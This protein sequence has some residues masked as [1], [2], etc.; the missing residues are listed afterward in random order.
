MSPLSVSDTLPIDE[1]YFDVVI[2]DE[3]SQITLEEGLPP[4]YRAKQSIIVGDEMQMPPSNFFGS[5]GDNKDDLW[6]D[7]GNELGNEYFSLDADSFLTQGARKFPSIMLGWH[8]RS[9]HEALIGFS[10]ASFYNN[11]LL[12]IPDVKDHQDTQTNIVVDIVDDAQENVHFI[13]QKPI[14]YHYIKNGVYESRSNNLEAKY[15]ALL[16]KEL[17]LSENK[18]SIGIVAFSME[19]E[20]ESEIQELCVSDKVFENRLEEEYKRIEDNQ[21]VGLFVKN[22][23]NVQGDERDIIIMST[24]FGYNPKGKML[25]NFGP[26][27]RRG[28][29][30]RLNVIFSRAKKSMVVVSS[31]KYSDITNE[32]NDG[33]NYFR[34]YLQYAELMSQ[35]NM[36]AANFV[37]NAIAANFESPSTSTTLQE[38]KSNLENLGYF[39]VENVGQSKFKCDLAIKNNATDKEFLLG[40]ILDEASHYE[41]SDVL[42]QYLLKPQL[43]EFNGWK[44]CQIYAKDWLEN[45]ERVL[46]MIQ[47]NVQN[48]TF[49]EKTTPPLSSV[50]SLKNFDSDDLIL[51]EK[52]EHVNMKNLETNIDSVF[53][54]LVSTENGSNKFW[55]IACH[56][57]ELIIQ[58]GR[59]GTKGQKLIKTF[60]SESKAMQE[61]SVLIK[62]KVNKGY[63]PN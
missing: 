32:Y 54:R 52:T 8:Y 56:G 60:E 42:E 9:K 4:I 18:Q 61:M 44:I 48:G 38:I 31:I 16:I 22:L 39:V 55:E 13:F 40:I 43:L 62:Q 10:N 25:M 1:N 28:G 33:A 2:F 20:I 30:K 3:A 47:T 53:T 23:E 57:T 58:Y 7:E 14:S 49:F 29:E 59:V 17:L 12:T 37:L 34:K 63:N 27:N 11:Q 24:C 41:Y 6:F 36:E 45:K 21:F 35:G 5:S 15:I 50:E 19:Q 26:I 46:S 51:N